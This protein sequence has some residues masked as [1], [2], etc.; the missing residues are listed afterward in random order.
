ME[1]LSLGIDARLGND[2]R[3]GSWFTLNLLM[4]STSPS[5][6]P[7]PKSDFEHSV[8]G[9]IRQLIQTACDSA[10]VVQLNLQPSS[11]PSQTQNQKDAENGLLEAKNYLLG[12]LDVVG[13]E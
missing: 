7:D 6:R 9:S 11:G 12:K 4:C 1:V 8:E 3:S 10:H 13:Q 5:S 2:L